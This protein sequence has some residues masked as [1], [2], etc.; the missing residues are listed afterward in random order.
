M[1]RL[2]CCRKTTLQQPAGP[3]KQAHAERTTERSA[4]GTMQMGARSG[5][6]PSRRRVT[7]Q[8]GL[9]DSGTQAEQDRFQ[10]PQARLPSMTCPGLRLASAWP[11]PLHVPRSQSCWPPS[12]DCV[13]AST[14]ESGHR[15]SEAPAI[16]APAV[17]AHPVQTLLQ[18]PIEDRPRTRAPE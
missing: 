13:I 11:P 14:T 7:A 1:R 6:A 4:A 9:R 16:A 15:D 8:Q 17:R 18:S 2:S 5:F 12:I 3:Q 10:S